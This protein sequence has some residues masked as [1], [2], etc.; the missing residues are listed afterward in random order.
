MV[1]ILIQSQVESIATQPPLKKKKRKSVDRWYS[2]TVNTRPKNMGKIKL[3]RDWRRDTLMQNLQYKVATVKWTHVPTMKMFSFPTP[4]PVDMEWFLVKLENAHNWSYPIIPI[5]V[6]EEF[7]MT[8]AAYE[9][10]DYTVNVSFSKP[11][12]DNFK[13]LYCHI[14]TTKQNLKEW[15]CDKY[16]EK[17]PKDKICRE[18]LMRNWDNL[19]I[20][21]NAQDKSDCILPNEPK[22]FSL[23]DARR[24]I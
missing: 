11:K 9:S 12:Y 19:D 21:W 20:S 24:F 7:S 15:F 5:S 2:S 16:P 6:R 23:I 14:C 10:E 22:Q 1:N 13:L 3:I 18:E 8:D 4:V 17:L